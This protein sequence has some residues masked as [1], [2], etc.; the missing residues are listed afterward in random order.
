MVA[1]QASGCAPIVRAFEAGE[2]RAAPWE[3]AAPTSAFGLRVPGALGDFLILRAL[4]ESGGNISQAARL[5]GITRQ[6]LLYRLE[7]HG[8]KDA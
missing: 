6:T 2:E 1:V 7:K 3:D 5:L 4:R 8:L